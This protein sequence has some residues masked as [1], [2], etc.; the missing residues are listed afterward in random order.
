LAQELRKD[1]SDGSSFLLLV[2]ALMSQIADRSLKV[3]S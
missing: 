3:F 2:G 1:V